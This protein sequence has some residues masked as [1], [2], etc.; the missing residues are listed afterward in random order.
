MLR[1]R[2]LFHAE[3]GVTVSLEPRRPGLADVVPELY[4]FQQVRLPAIP[5]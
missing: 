2:K 5:L 4:D 1:L 3:I